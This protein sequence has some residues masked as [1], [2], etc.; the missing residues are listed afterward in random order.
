MPENVHGRAE[1]VSLPPRIGQLKSQPAEIGGEGA[2]EGVGVGEE[3][4]VEHR[5]LTVPRHIDLVHFHHLSTQPHRKDT[6]GK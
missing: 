1:H 4:Q 3:K 5:L 2:D 6:L